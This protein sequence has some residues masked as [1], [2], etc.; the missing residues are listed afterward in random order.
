MM[1]IT[2]S[3]FKKAQIEIKKLKEQQEKKNNYSKPENEESKKDNS[4]MNS[5]ISKN[6]AIQDLI[7]KLPAEKKNGIEIVCKKNMEENKKSVLSEINGK[8]LAKCNCGKIKEINLKC[9]HMIC[10]ACSENIMK[11]IENNKVNPEAIICGECNNKFK[12]SK[13]FNKSMLKNR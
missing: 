2:S 9:G 3:L 7:V 6:S 11:K 1:N 4:N 8:I 5:P 10:L 12:I 13:S